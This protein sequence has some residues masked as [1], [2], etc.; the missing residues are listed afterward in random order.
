MNNRWF[1]SSLFFTL[2]QEC[3]LRRLSRIY[4]PNG[5]LTTNYFSIKSLKRKHALLPTAIPIFT[6][7]ATKELNLLFLHYSRNFE[8]SSEN[9]WGV[10]YIIIYTLQTKHASTASPTTISILAILNELMLV[11]TKF[12]CP[13]VTKT[14]KQNVVVLL[15]NNNSFKHIWE[16]FYFIY[17]WHYA[18][19]IWKEIL[20]LVWT[21]SIMS[22]GI[23][24]LVTIVIQYLEI[25]RCT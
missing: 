24:I 25:G 1:D 19:T 20:F 6:P 12:L 8:Y 23:L 4:L 22:S 11:K 15:K 7:A 9:F 18:R 13:Q 2:V 17:L 10:K 21:I 14:H 3:V 5:Q 16:T